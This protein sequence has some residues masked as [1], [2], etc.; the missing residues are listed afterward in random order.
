MQNL[1]EVA[2]G[3]MYVSDKILFLS[4]VLVI[5]TSFP[6]QIITFLLWQCPACISPESSYRLQ[7]MTVSYSICTFSIFQFAVQ[8]RFF[9]H[10]ERTHIPTWNILQSVWHCQLWTKCSQKLKKEMPMKN[11]LGGVCEIYFS[12]KITFSWQ[13]LVILTSF[14]NQTITSLFMEMPLL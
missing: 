2:S 1:S 5:L 3:K 4:L 13:L 12:E 14:S 11:L 7:H 8:K 9:F 10:F 6:K